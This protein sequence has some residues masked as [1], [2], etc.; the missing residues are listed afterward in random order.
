M[1]YLTKLSGTPCQDRVR[2]PDG[3]SGT[4]RNVFVEHISS[5][6]Y[7]GV[8]GTDTCYS[9]PSEGSTPSGTLSI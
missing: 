6:R 9:F 5:D 2:F 7:Y 8:M 4:N 3:L 1:A